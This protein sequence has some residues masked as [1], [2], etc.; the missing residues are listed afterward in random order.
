MGGRGVGQFCWDGGLLIERTV[1]APGHCR[2]I[3]ARGD[4]V[5][6]AGA[7]L[8]DSAN[9]VGARELPERIASPAD[10]NLA[11]RACANEATQGDNE[12]HANELVCRACAGEGPD[13]GSSGL[14]TE[15]FHSLKHTAGVVRPDR[16]S[17][18]P[19]VLLTL[20]THDFCVD[21]ARAMR[22]RR[23][24][25]NLVRAPSRG[26]SRSR[27]RARGSARCPAHRSIHRH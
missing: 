14:H 12:R 26:S 23:N 18:S 20:S 11:V 3:G 21:L 1:E 4:I 2:A 8:A 10:N 6:E 9:G 7:D 13:G 22:P 19:R 27:H 16:P 15:S 25:T 5:I 24:L 17:E